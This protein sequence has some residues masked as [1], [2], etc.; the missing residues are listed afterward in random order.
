MQKEVI[1]FSEEDRV[2]VWTAYYEYV[3]MTTLYKNRNG[4][5]CYR[6]TPVVTH[7]GRHTLSKDYGNTRA[8]GVLDGL[9]VSK[10]VLSEEESKIYLRKHPCPEVA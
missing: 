3:P 1:R 4:R 7:N 9:L 5:T 10:V 2:D 6:R 8:F